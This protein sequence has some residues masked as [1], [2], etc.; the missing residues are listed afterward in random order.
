MAAQVKARQAC[1]TRGFNGAA[2]LCAKADAWMVAIAV[3]R[4]AK[5]GQQL[6]ESLVLFVAACVL[7]ARYSFGT[8]SRAMQSHAWR[9]ALQAI[10]DAP[11]SGQVRAWLGFLLFRWSMIVSKRDHGP[12]ISCIL[13]YPGTPGRSSFQRSS[14][15]QQLHA[16]RRALWAL[17]SGCVPST[18]HLGA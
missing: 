7:C 6:D 4:A 12:L 3:L 10:A 8:L 9:A 17:A 16:E 1:K 2:K 11:V 18:L 5:L 14:R 15:S 13:A